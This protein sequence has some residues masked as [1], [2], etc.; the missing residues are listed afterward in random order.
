MLK[1]VDKWHLALF[2][3]YAILI[4]YF[5]NWRPDPHEY[6]IEHG[7]EWFETLAEIRSKGL[8]NVFIIFFASFATFVFAS[9]IWAN[10]QNQRWR[11]LLAMIFMI[12]SGAFVLI[13]SFPIITGGRA[14]TGMLG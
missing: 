13:S 8:R 14:P 12:G 3:G 4:F 9:R 1:F 11:R 5:L 10:V 6:M 7:T 2:L